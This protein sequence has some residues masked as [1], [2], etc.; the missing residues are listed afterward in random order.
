MGIRSSFLIAKAEH[1]GFHAHPDGD[2]GRVSGEPDT[3]AISAYR[4]LQGSSLPRL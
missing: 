4:S 1:G 2:L 3:G